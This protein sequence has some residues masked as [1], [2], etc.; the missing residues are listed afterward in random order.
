MIIVI[1]LNKKIK[2]NKK[3]EKRESIAQNLKEIGI[4]IKIND[5]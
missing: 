4:T 1:L 5:F 2:R 3:E